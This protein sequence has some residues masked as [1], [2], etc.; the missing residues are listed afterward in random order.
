[1]MCRR[2]G[3]SGSRFQRDDAKGEPALQTIMNRLLDFLRIRQ[4]GLDFVAESSRL[5][6]KRI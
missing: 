4:E 3:A 5:V 2:R 1:M 6:E